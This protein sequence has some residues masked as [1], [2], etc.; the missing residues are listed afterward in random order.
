MIHGTAASMGSRAPTH[1]H[2]GGGGGWG[3][4]GT[5]RGRGTSGRWAAARWEN[6]PSLPGETVLAVLEDDGMFYRGRVIDRRAAVLEIGMTNLEGGVVR[7]DHVH[8]ANCFR[9]PDPPPGP[10]EVVPGDP[11]EVAPSEPIYVLAPDPTGSHFGRGALQGFLPG[12]VTALVRRGADAPKYVVLILEF[13]IQHP[14][15]I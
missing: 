4:D 5:G 9:F 8:R 10:G 3:N 11:D 13:E 2:I 7:V 6:E 12:I 15:G 1:D 14:I